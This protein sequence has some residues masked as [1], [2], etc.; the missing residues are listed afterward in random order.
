M[1]PL[2]V[3]SVWFYEVAAEFEATAVAIDGVPIIGEYLAMP[4]YWMTYYI[5]EAAYWL[6]EADT[7]ISS[8]D[9]DSIID[10]FSIWVM[11]WLGAMPWDFIFFED[12]LFGFCLYKMG[13]PMMDAL[14]ASYDLLTYLQWRMIV[15]WGFLEDLV[16]DAAGW[17]RDQIVDMWPILEGLFDDPIAWVM[18]RLEADMWEVLLF[19]DDIPA[20]LFYRLTGSYTDALFFKWNLIEYVKWKLRSH[21]PFLDEI[22]LDPLGWFWRNLMEAIDTY[23]DTHIEW[24]VSTCGRV[25]S[26]IWQ[27][28]V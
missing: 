14:M 8:L 17:I 11:T 22:L 21:W 5:N 27:T 18:Y 7:W 25:I 3:A 13:L 1:H 28:E 26:L 23:I 24:L 10:N 19:R 12:N 15:W 16:Y 6:D 4:F 20:W 2:R 9:V